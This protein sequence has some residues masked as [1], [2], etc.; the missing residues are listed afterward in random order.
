MKRGGSFG[1]DQHITIFSPD[2]RLFQLE[3]A[4]KAS[5]NINSTAI[6]LKNKNSIILA[7]IKK[8]IDNQNSTNSGF[9]IFPMTNLMGCIFAGF[10]SDIEMKIREITRESIDFFQK[11]KQIIPVDI[12][13][14]RVSESSQI[15]TQYAFMR[16]LVVR[17][18]FMAIDDEIG[19]QILKCEPSGRC[20][21]HF[22]CLMGEKENFLNSK[23]ISQ[24]NK[25]LKNSFSPSSSIQVA[26]GIL[27]NLFNHNFKVT[28]LDMVLLNKETYSFR[29][30]SQKEK[31]FL[32]TTL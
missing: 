26:L 28:D 25:K 20:S 12:L 1:Y 4:T 22:F 23:T 11:Y 7:M 31:E 32:R 16:P 17:T 30:L 10:S 9:K 18:V 21:S 8:N 15:F 27:K 5:K 19:P 3:Y 2:G 13:S 24:L 14:Q 6:I 29:R